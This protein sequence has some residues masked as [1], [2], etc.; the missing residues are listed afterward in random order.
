MRWLPQSLDLTK[1][2]NDVDEVTIADTELKF[3]MVV[4][5]G[6]T[7]KLSTNLI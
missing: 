3:N 2:K 1:P 4:A 5:E 6:H 7:E